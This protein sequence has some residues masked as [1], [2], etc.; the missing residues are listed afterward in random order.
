MT[1]R[2]INSKDPSTSPLTKSLFASR[3]TH[4]W[5]DGEMPFELGPMRRAS[6]HGRDW[7]LSLEA[8]SC[9]RDILWAYWW[10]RM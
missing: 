10:F 6:Q 5:T 9:V 2:S 7:S 8:L 4:A 1:N 3:E